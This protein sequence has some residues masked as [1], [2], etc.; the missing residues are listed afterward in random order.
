MK[1]FGIDFKPEKSAELQI[2]SVGIKWVED[3]FL[4]L[5]KVFGHKR[6]DQIPFS[7]KYFPK[8]FSAKEIKIENL[9]S[10][11][12]S[13][14]ELD[15][16]IFSYEIFEDIRDSV[17][18][19]Y[20]IEGH[21]I[22]SYLEIDEITGK[23]LLSVAKSTFNYPNRL[24][25]SICYEFTKAKLIQSK[26]KYDNGKDTNLFLYLAVVYFGYGLIIGQNIIDIGVRSNGLYQTTWSFKSEIP[27]PVIAYSLAVFARLKNDLN[28]V[29]KNQLP[30]EIKKEF[31]LS[32]EYI[33]KSK[34]DLFDAVL[35][36]NTL[37]ADKLFRLACEQYQKGEINKAISTSQKDLFF[38]DDLSMKSTVYNNIGYY[39]LRQSQY[40]SSIPD[41]ENALKLNPNFGFAYNNVGFALIMSGDLDQGKEYL[42]LAIKTENNNNAYSYRNLAIYYQKIGEIKLAENY[43]QK[44]FDQKVPID[45]LDYFYGKFL[46]EIGDYKNGL[47]HIKASADLG[48]P[49]G[50][51]FLEELIKTNHELSTFP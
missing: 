48:E 24:I 15:F 6:E 33:N 10:D 43:F 16:D 38:I 32:L 46:I 2:T 12:C 39:K 27:Y 7:E 8:T 34:N 25:C 13:H 4:W 51:E 49:E 26:V 40:K 21:L 19:P 1:L 35:K 20:T 30:K 17:N 9:I 42:E 45:V 22:D 29:W 47:E 36:E 28:P 3:N 14:L 37:K 50:K 31:E 44:A 18:M 11:C 23:Y 41:F 5:V